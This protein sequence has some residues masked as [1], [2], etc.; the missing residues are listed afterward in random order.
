[1]FSVL[2]SVVQ[3][4]LFTFLL[5]TVHRSMCT[6]HCALCIVHCA[7]CTLCS[8]ACAT[9]PVVGVELGAPTRRHWRETDKTTFY[10][11]LSRIIWDPRC[12]GFNWKIP[13]GSKSRPLY[14]A[15]KVLIWNGICPLSFNLEW[16]MPPKLQFLTQLDHWAVLKVETFGCHGKN[17]PQKLQNGLEGGTRALSV[18]F[19]MITTQKWSNTSRTEEFSIL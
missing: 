19:V 10:Y 1:M 17:H 9:Q 3:C 18:P 8:V 4:S 6:L 12:G 14:H 5:F 16:N 15:P 13:P 11:L 7:L 2:C